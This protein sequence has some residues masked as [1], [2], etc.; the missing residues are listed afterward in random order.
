MV[1]SGQVRSG[2]RRGAVDIAS[3]ESHCTS[4]VSM[5]WFPAGASM[6]APALIHAEAIRRGCVYAKRRRPFIGCPAAGKVRAGRSWCW[7]LRGQ[8]LVQDGRVL[9]F[10]GPAR[11]TSNLSVSYRAVRVS[12]ETLAENFP[13]RKNTGKYDFTACALAEFQVPGVRARTCLGCWAAGRPSWTCPFRT[14]GDPHAPWGFDVGVLSQ[15][16][17]IGQGC[18]PTIASD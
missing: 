16:S 8:I 7:G 9:L 18:N 12:W 17:H 3:M 15:P 13:P 1:V 4:P 11:S 5:S 6:I 2:C 14:R 10:W